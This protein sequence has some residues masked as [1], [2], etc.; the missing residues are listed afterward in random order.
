MSS[1]TNP[2]SAF[3]EDARK[4]IFAALVAAQDQGAGVAASREQVAK[5]FDI[6]VDDVQTVEKEGLEKGWPPL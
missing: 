4:E 2:T 1:E 3:P 5:E 6:T